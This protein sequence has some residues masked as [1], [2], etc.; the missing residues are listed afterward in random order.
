M[1]PNTINYGKS[2]YL[3]NLVFLKE[4]NKDNGIHLSACQLKD[5]ARRFSAWEEEHVYSLENGYEDFRDKVI[6]MDYDEI[7]EMYMEE[8]AHPTVK[9]SWQSDANHTYFKNRILPQI[10]DMD[11]SR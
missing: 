2:N 5:M 9:P 10:N 7:L 6:W 4:Y 1:D 3:T 8:V 11:K